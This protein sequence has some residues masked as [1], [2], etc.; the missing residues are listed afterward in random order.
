MQT[1]HTITTQ[2]VHDAFSLRGLEDGGGGLI[3]TSDPSLY[4][5][6]ERLRLARLVL[7]LLPTGATISTAGK[8]AEVLAPSV[9]QA[10]KPTAADKAESP[11]MFFS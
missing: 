9:A 5:S 2:A 3:R 6:E 8:L 11:V 4:M 10:M 7:R 1:L